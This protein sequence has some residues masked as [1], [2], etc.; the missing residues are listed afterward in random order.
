ML[1]KGIYR[2]YDSL[3]WFYNRYW[4][5]KY[6]VQILPVLDELLLS[7]LPAR[8]RI[9]DLCCGTGHLARMLSGHGFR[10]TGIDGSE[11]MLRYARE[12]VPAGEFISADA[13]NY[14]MPPVFQAAVSTFESLNHVSSIGELMIVFQNTCAGLARDGLFVFDLLMEEAYRTRWDKSSAIV[15]E[16]NVCIMRGGYNTAV[17][18]GRTDITMFRLEG[19]WKRS[20]VTLLQRCYSEEEVRAALERTGFEGICTYHAGKDFEMPGDLGIGRVFFLAKKESHL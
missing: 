7:C 18:I 5:E 3:A 12:N 9:L 2:D 17:R 8:A 10:V 13:R 16:D 6:H 14:K 15:D 4:G 11:E 19:H 20:D 1:I